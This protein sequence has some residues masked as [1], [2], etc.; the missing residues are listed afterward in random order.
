VDGLPD[1]ANVA[2]PPS[3]AFFTRRLTRGTTLHAEVA[4]RLAGFACQRSR[5]RLRHNAF[6][7]H[8]QDA[9]LP[10][11]RFIALTAFGAALTF[12]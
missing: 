12:E 9:R 2:Q 5:G 4:N 11:V 10:S 8:G 3:P 7:D 1:I 6:P